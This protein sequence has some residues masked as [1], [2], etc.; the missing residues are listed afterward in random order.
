MNNIKTNIKPKNKPTITVY[1]KHFEFV[2]Y[3]NMRPQPL[4]GHVVRRMC[5]MYAMS[6]PDRYVVR[7]C[8][9]QILTVIHGNHMWSGRMIPK[10]LVEH[11]SDN[12]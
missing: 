6:L 10:E 1:D 7:K 9:T 4:I 11:F 12:P 8:G 2:G 3:L 5:L